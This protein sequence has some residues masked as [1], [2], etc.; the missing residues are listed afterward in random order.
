M[1][2][3]INIHDAKTHL[4]RLVE[5]AAQGK[6]IVIAKAGKPMAR[7]VPLENAPRP[8]KFGLLEGR[9]KVPDDFDAPLDP[10]VLALFEG[11]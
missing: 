5:Q 10:R 4:S 9:F 11:S 1:S 6:E 8:K 2:K 7:L 3:A